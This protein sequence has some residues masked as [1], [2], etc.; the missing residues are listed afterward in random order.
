[1]CAGARPVSAGMNTEHYGV[2]DMV[3]AMGQLGVLPAPPR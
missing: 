3:G 1:M 2:Y